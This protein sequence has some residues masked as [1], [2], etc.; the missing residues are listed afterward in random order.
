MRLLAVIL[1]L[2]LLFSSTI[3][4]SAEEQPNLVG[5]YW[6]GIE[7]F[8]SQ[9]L[10]GAELAEIKL[11]NATLSF[12]SGYELQV[13]FEGDILVYNDISYCDGENSGDLNHHYVTYA[14]PRPIDGGSISLCGLHVNSWG[15][16]AFIRLAGGDPSTLDSPNP[17]I[18]DGAGIAHEANLLAGPWEVCAV[19]NDSEWGI[20]R[21]VPSTW[22]NIKSM[23]R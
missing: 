17:V 7:G 4:Q 8:I 6:Q 22:D 18:F 21:D 13:H 19:L 23:F 2:F 9:N 16:A 14:S 1:G 10:N 3:A 11:S 15:G 5:F 20:V 12:I